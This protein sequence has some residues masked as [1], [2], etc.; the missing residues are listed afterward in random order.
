NNF[1]SGSF[2]G[3]IG[4]GG[5]P[6]LLSTAIIVLSIIGIAKQ[7][8]KKD[9]KTKIDFSGFSFVLITIILTVIYFLTWIYVGYFYIVSFIYIFILMFL[10]GSKAKVSIKKRFYINIPIIIGL[11]LT[12]Y[13]LFDVFLST[14]F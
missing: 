12:I 1:D 4:S 14:R 5:F 2:E 3:G 9:K 7:M 11:L 10:F 6:K 8:I 13:F